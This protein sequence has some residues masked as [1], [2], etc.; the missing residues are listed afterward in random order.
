MSHIHI[1]DGYLP[2]WLCILGFLIVGIYIFFLSKYIKKN[3]K[4][5]KLVLVG[6]FSALMMVAMSLEIVPISYHV[7]LSALTGIIL[8][9]VFSPLA[10]LVTNMFLALM[11]HGGVT[12]I[13]L[14]SIV[15]SVEAIVAFYIFKFLNSRLK[16]PVFS[17]IVATFIALF[18]STW[19][20]VGII[21]IGTGTL[22]ESRHFE[23]SGFNL[24]RV[25]GNEKEEMPDKSNF[26][27]KKFILLIFSLG[28]IG[29]SIEALVTAFIVNYVKQ[30]KP[31][32]MENLNE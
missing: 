20:S 29:W 18:V 10:V 2:L 9:P 24:I 25:E 22:G 32:L 13:G 6:I 14:N 26:D 31:E 17:T 11:G 30:I 4:H 7:N 15:V 27:I 21:Y 23:K 1:P 8:G 19:M 16:K 5:N 3:E 28:L 12:V